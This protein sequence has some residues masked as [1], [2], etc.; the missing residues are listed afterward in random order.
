M[1][2]L[3]FCFFVGWSCNVL[4]MRYG[5]VLL[6]KKLRYFFV[7]LIIGDFLMG[8]TWAIIGLFSDASYPVLPE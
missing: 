8:G 5:G 3:W 4:C 2:I 1:R 7:G 6:F